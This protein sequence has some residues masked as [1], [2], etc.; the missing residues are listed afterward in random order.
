MSTTNF[1]HIT[2]WNMNGGPIPPDAVK[3]I[4]DT[5]EK[6]VKE[7]EEKDSVRLLYTVTSK[8]DVKNGIA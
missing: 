2:V 7:T 3:T 5:I 1:A 8:D 6:V 4:T